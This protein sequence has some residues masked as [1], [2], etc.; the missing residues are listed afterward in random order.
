MTTPE[1]I[2]SVYRL[3]FLPFSLCSWLQ[4]TKQRP[5]CAYTHILKQHV[6]FGMLCGAS[7]HHWWSLFFCSFF[8]LYNLFRLIRISL[9]PSAPLVS[10]ELL[11]D[12]LACFLW[13]YFLFQF[14]RRKG[15]PIGYHLCTFLAI[16]SWRIMGPQ[17]KIIF[18]PVKQTF[19]FFYW[20]FLSL[21][22]DDNVY[23]LKL[24]KHKQS[25]N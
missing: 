1:V 23:L 17:A 7:K 5:K 9:S 18:F 6:F 20:I 2:V 16:C 25:F 13:A 4:N 10:Y 19:F 14:W 24:K 3:F 11:A 15:L 12:W 21:T 8:Y 22:A